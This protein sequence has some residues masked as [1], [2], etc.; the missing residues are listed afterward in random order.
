MN[1]RLDRKLKNAVETSHEHSIKQI[2]MGENYL[3]VEVHVRE[4]S[5]WIVA[6][7]TELTRAL[8][9]ELTCTLEGPYRATACN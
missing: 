2:S 8:V 4:H 9:S 5:V 1:V 3:L 6:S 7:M